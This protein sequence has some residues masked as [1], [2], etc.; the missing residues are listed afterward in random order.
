MTKLFTAMVLVCAVTMGWAADKVVPAP[1]DTKTD[2]FI[3]YTDKNGK[4]SKIAEVIPAKDGKPVSFK[5]YDASKERYKEIITQ[6]IIN[7]INT[8]M[9]LRD[10]TGKLEKIVAVL[11]EGQEAAVPDQSPAAAVTEPVKK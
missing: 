10:Q 4:E 11:N 7:H 1:P 9:A 8:Y 3:Y 5:V 2:N 6:I